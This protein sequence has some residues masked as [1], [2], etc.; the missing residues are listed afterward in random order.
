[1]GLAV[2]DGD[3]VGGGDAV[4]AGR[5]TWHLAGELLAYPS[6]KW[7]YGLHT[8][9]FMCS[10][11]QF[12]PL[13]VQMGCYRSERW[14]HFCSW[15]ERRGPLHAVIPG[16]FRQ[17]GTWEAGMSPPV[18][19]GLGARSQWT[20]EKDRRWG[21]GTSHFPLL[22]LLFFFTMSMYHSYKKHEC[23]WYG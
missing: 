18:R 7:F 4:G 21:W 22:Q 12:S 16:G 23:F 15:F 2:G 11:S 14:L 3:A 5:C 17:R 13:L 6:S 1:M 20:V 10:F 19:K 8:V 9:P